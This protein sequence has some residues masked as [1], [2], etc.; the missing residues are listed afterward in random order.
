MQS[1]TYPE[2]RDTSVILTQ[3]KEIASAVMYAAEA[4]KLETVLERIAQV[5]LQLVN[6]QYAAI[7][8]P[9][10]IGG[11]R[12]FKVAGLT[13]EQAAKLIHL[14]LGRGL[15]GAIMQERKSIRLSKMQSDPRSVGFC[16]AHPEMTSLLGVPIQIG[17]QLFGTFYLCDRRDNSP[18]DEQDEWLLEILAGY[19]AVAIASSE[20]NEQQS[21]LA[22][23]E[24]R[25][26]IAMDLHDGIIQSLYGIGMHLELMRL[27]GG[28]SEMELGNTV[29]SLNDVIEDIRRYIM[30]LNGRNQNEKS[31]R[32]SLLEVLGRLYTPDSLQIIVEAPETSAPFTPAVF[33]AI[34]QMANEAISNAIRHAEA[35]LITI[36]AEQIKGDFIISVVDNGRGFDV[37][38]L[39]H[40]EGLGLKNLQQR[41]ALLSGRV[42][43]QSNSGEGT[44]LTITMPIR[45]Y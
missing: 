6:A 43:V 30:D 39:T 17:Q 34:C 18:F 19:A 11:L 5:S 40:T 25:E 23:L 12:F 10:G 14:P 35:T 21:R 44:R 8:V 20:L 3:L 9:D 45:A 33:E 28:A 1:D 13:P 26:R 2:K 7:G 24:D 16:A 22:L 41:A 29:S 31:I 15:I 42:T 32:I 38:K 37:T 4:D 27:S 36:R